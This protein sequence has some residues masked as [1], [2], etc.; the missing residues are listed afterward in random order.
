MLCLSLANVATP[1]TSR[2]SRREPRGKAARP[3]YLKDVIA[4]QALANGA[5]DSS[6]EEGAGKE[7]GGGGKAYG[8]RKSAG[9]HTGVRMRGVSIEGVYITRVLPLSLPQMRSSVASSGSSWRPHRGVLGHPHHHR[10]H[11]HPHPHYLIL[12]LTPSRVALTLA[13]CSAASND[14]PR[15]ARMARWR[16]RWRLHWMGT[17]GGAV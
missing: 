2:I 7:R 12:I 9:Q 3:K 17:L 11:H 14:T 15:R 8:E 13:A 1:A 10:P 16:P 5:V 6:D 4:E